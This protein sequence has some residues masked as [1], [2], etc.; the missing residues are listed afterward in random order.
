MNITINNWQDV[1][2]A[3]QCSVDTMQLKGYE[4]VDELFADSSGFGADDEP[5]LS[6]S[7][8][9]RKIQQ[10]LK[11]H[12]KLTAKITSFGM[13]Q[14]Y[15]GLFKKTGKKQAK[16]LASNV[17]LIDK[18]DGKR[19]VRLY[20]TD[21]LT[22]NG[23]GTITVDNGDYATRTTHKRINEFSTLYANSKNYETYINGTKLSEC[24]TYKAELRV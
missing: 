9:E 10:L 3:K 14:V 19:I 12:G 20:D 17:L 16:L 24:S 5:A 21:I 7:Q 11:E 2:R 1:F 13:F 23:D 22:E 15:V 4:L 8:F 6:V 18:G